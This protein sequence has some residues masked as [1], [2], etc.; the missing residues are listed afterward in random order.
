MTILSNYTMKKYLFLFITAISFIIIQNVHA[1]NKGGFMAGYNLSTVSSE[2]IDISSKSGYQFGFIMNFY[3]ENKGILIEPQLCWIGYGYTIAGVD[4][5]NKLT[6]FKLPVRYQY[7]LLLENNHIYFN[8][9]LY[10][11]RLLKVTEKLNGKVNQINDEPFA[12]HTLGLNFGIGY[13]IKKV[14]LGVEYEHS[15]FNIYTNENKM[16]SH[17]FCVNVRLFW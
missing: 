10:Y 3:K 1:D 12:N 16:I 14:Q 17:S 6:Y 9:G 13:G 8:S 7:K 5:T 11:G 15:L 2:K 4:A